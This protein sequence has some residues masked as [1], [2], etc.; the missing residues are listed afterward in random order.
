M[1]SSST[2]VMCHVTS[3]TNIPICGATET[4]LWYVVTLRKEYAIIYPS[5]PCEQDVQ[6]PVGTSCSQ[7]IRCA[8]GTI[9]LIPVYMILIILF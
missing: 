5:C 3:S 1:G 8:P 2:D 4:L 9:F 7:S 6:T